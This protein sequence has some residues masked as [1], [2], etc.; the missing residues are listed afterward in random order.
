MKFIS[1]RPRL[2]KLPNYWANTAAIRRRW[3][4]PGGEILAA[5]GQA[6][7]RVVDL[8]VPEVCQ[9]CGHAGGFDAPLEGASAGRIALCESC[10]ASFLARVPWCC[11][12]CAAPLPPIPELPCPY[13][14]ERHYRFEATLSLGLY[15]GRVR[16]AVLKMKYGFH[17]SLTLAVGGL[18]A[19]RL[20]EDDWL[21]QVDLVAPV[22]LHLWKRLVRGASA[23]ELLAEVV[24]RDGKTPVVPNL[25]RCCRRTRKQGTLLPGERL[26]NVR[27]AFEVASCYDI[28]LARVLLVD[29]VMTTGATVN[30]AARVLLQAGAASVRVATV[31]RGTGQ[32]GSPSK[33][34]DQQGSRRITSPGP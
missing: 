22:P 15:W 1:K 16:Q 13:C 12:R 2:L 20:R 6:I 23:P 19:R 11:T 30:E 33:L 21:R 5:I 27:G 7:G 34:H 29:D 3:I 32:E 26:T 24:G 9:L 17:E 28:K 18:L 8:I 14:R 10:A 4:M 25:L 31:A